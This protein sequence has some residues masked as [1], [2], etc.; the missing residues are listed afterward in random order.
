LN[1]LA[2]QV[3]L[4]ETA[5]LLLPDRSDQDGTEHLLVRALHGPDAVDSPDWSVA[6]GLDGLAQNLLL[7][8]RNP[9][10]QA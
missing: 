6:A 7:S 3:S 4:A 8:I 1:T 5:S 9:F 10:T 2:A